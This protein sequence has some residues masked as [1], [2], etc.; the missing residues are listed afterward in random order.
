MKRVDEAVGIIQQ[1]LRQA[2]IDRDTLVLINT[3]HGPELPRGKWTMLDGGLGIG[4]MVRYPAG[5]V[6]GGRVCDQLLCNAD[7][8]PTLAELTGL[9]VPHPMNGVS[10][11]KSVRGESTA[12]VREEIHGIYANWDY[13]VRTSRFKLT[14]RFQ[15]ERTEGLDPTGRPNL[16]P[17]VRLFDMEKDPLEL[18]NVAGDPAYADVL[19]HMHN[20]L[21]RHLEAVN[22]PI[23]RGP[24]PTPFY[25][26]AINDYHQWKELCSTDSE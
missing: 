17:A 26:K 24:V 11:A 3:D 21:W 4:F 2:G 12:A 22:D 14:R 5:G 9:P 6:S 23:L 10:F 16:M 18:T 13:S 15:G 25:N 7:F 20:R 1:G 8:L 19:T